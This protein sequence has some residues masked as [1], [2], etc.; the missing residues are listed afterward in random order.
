M[1]PR[2]STVEIIEAQDDPDFLICLEYI[3]H[4]EL[5]RKSD[6]SFA[7]YKGVVPSTVWRWKVQWTRSGLLMKTRQVLGLALFEDVIVANRRAIREWNHLLDHAI[8]L[9]KDS[10]SDFVRLQ[11][12]QWVYSQIVQPEMEKQQSSGSVEDEYIKRITQNPKALD[13]LAFARPPDPIDSED[14]RLTD[15]PTDLDVL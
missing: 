13:P 7:E 3:Q 14:E 15:P 9:A 10:R 4:V 1:P 2:K 11:A 8:A 5:E 12:I 6:T